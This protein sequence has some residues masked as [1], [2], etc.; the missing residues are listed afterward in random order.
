MGET[1]VDLLHLLE[2]LRDAY[3]GPTDESILT[4]I[5]ANA[6]DSGARTIS[7]VTDPVAATFTLVDDGL[8]MHRRELSRYHDLAISSKTRGQG[9]GFAGVGIKL[10]LL[11]SRE[12]V[13][14]TRR[15][16]RQVATSWALGGRQRAPWRWVSPPGLVGAGGTAVRLALENP[17]AP[18][19][20]A[21]FVEAS[22]RRH[23]QTL[24]DPFFDEILAAQYP[25]RIRFVVNG[26]TLAPEPWSG[27]HRRRPAAG[28]AP[29]PRGQHL[30]QGD[31]GRLGLAGRDAR[32]G[33]P[34][35][36]PHRGAGAGR[37]PDPQQG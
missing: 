21:G 15:A 16:G 13:T 11:V 7:V 23:F 34:H 17:L 36:R 19:L 26:R 2:D 22:L 31:Q 29:R 30:R 12:V 6:L 18:L 4:E 1:R 14:E 24:L 32:G 27:H 33:R 28:G 10:A 25:G 37:V 20:D 35:R 8:G 5:V 3:P 9:I